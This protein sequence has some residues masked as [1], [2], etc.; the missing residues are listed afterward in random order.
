MA[1]RRRPLV[2]TVDMNERTR[3]RSCTGWKEGGVI[4]LSG[5]LVARSKT[6]WLSVSSTEPAIRTSTRPR[7]MSSRPW[8]PNITSA[9]ML[10]ATK[11]GTLRPGSTRS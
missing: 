4:A 2:P 1:G 10:I 7:T 6:R 5:S 3:S 8:K 9:R 11:V